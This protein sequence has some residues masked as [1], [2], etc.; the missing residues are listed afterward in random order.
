VQKFYEMDNLK[1]LLNV[2]VGFIYS[3]HILQH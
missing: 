1:D 2:F 3:T